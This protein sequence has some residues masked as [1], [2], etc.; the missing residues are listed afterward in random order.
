MTVSGRHVATLVHG[1]CAAGPHVVRWDA[2]EVPS[3]LY[4]AVLR[5][6]GISTSARVVRIR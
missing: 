1:E 4:F 2:G 3:G 5:A 6:D